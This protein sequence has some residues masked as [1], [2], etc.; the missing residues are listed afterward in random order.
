MGR[1]GWARALPTY[2]TARIVLEK[3]L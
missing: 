3:E 2:H 1:K